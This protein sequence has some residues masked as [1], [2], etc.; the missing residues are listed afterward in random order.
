MQE[1]EI[2][3]EYRH[4]DRLDRLA[5]ETFISKIIVGKVDPETKKRNMNI[6]WNICC[7]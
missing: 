4:I 7:S 1:Q 3:K 2:F 6:V 5:V